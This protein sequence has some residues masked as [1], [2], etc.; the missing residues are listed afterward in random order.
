ME[1]GR[2]DEIN[3]DDLLTEDSSDELKDLVK[4]FELKYE[5]LKQKRKQQSQEQID[6]VQGVEVPR[7]PQRVA[8]ATATTDK[9]KPPSHID[10]ARPKSTAASVGVPVRSGSTA[11]AKSKP[12]AKG[13]S[14]NFLSKLYNTNFQPKS[15]IDYDQRKFEF[16]FTKTTFQTTNTP[17]KDPLTNQHLRKRFISTSELNKLLQST[18][19]KLKL[20]NIDKLLAKVTKE[21]NFSE[22]QYTNWC[23]IGTIL[24]KSP[25][26]LTKDK[27]T[28]YMKVK[29]GD[30]NHAIDVLIFDQ[31]FEKNWKIQ[32]GNLSMLLNPIINKYGQGFNLKLD[33]SNRSSLV[34]IGSLRDFSNC[35]F[36][37]CKNVINPTKQELCD[38]HLDLKYNKSGRMEL[39]GTISMRRPTYAKGSE[40]TS[41]FQDYNEDTVVSSGITPDFQTYQDPKILQTKTKRRKLI[42]SKANEKLQLKLSKLSSNSS[43]SN[44]NL[45]KHK[46]DTPNTGKFPNSMISQIGYDP[47]NTNVNYIKDDIKDIRIKELYELSNSTSSKKQLTVSK[48]DL[49]VKLDKYKSNLKLLEKKESVGESL[50]HVRHK[51]NRIE[52]DSDDDDIN[53]DFGNE[54]LKEQYLK[55]VSKP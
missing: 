20:L 8:P 6:Q 44:L 5:K 22:P 36:E 43:L 26:L 54:R 55:L 34:E 28:K 21:N 38:L 10:S 35:K 11:A 24:Y 2:F 3:S 32:P 17:E 52:L 49:Q 41:H 48:Q 1:D 29:I 23:L 53:I 37:N 47:T 13:K 14:S 25:P 7:S 46:P 30:F 12:T 31:A 19:P 33:N 15:T 16:D 42:E 40:V 45:I 4:E 51:H 27:Q 9:P 18:D 50:V 39:N